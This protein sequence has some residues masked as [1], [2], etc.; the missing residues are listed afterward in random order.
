MPC[1]TVG[2]NRPTCLIKCKAAKNMPCAVLKITKNKTLILALG[3]VL[4][5]HLTALD[6]SLQEENQLA[7]KQR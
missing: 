4:S 3:K 2:S 5:A 1:A 7:T 6:L